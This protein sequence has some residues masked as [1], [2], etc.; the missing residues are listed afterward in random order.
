MLQNIITILIVAG[1]LGWAGWQA[2]RWLV[3]SAKGGGGCA[4]GCG[5]GKERSSETS[6]SA[7]NPG[8]AQTQFLPSEDLVAR[9]KARKG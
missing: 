4:G 5:C 9:I 6:T 8:K 1:A 2:Y 3:P 7:K